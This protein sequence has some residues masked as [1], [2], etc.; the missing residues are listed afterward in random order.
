MRTQVF[1]ID[2]FQAAVRKLGQNIADVREFA[3]GENIFFN[4]FAHAGAQFAVVD[5]AGG[6]AVV[7]HQPARTTQTPNLGTLALQLRDPAVL[8]HA[9]G[10]DFVRWRG[11]FELSLVEKVTHNAHAQPLFF[12]QHDRPLIGLG[13]SVGIR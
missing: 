10:S 2:A 11:F 7:E 4:E 1:D 8:T 3:T 6:N 13:K 5:A 9:Y 12:D